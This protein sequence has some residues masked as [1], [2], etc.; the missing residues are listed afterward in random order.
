M[1]IET[2]AADDHP[3]CVSAKE[4]AWALG[5]MLQLMYCFQDPVAPSNERR[6][7]PLLETPCWGYFVVQMICNEGYFL[8]TCPTIR[9]LARLAW[10]EELNE[11]LPVA[12]F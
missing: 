4:M 7:C 11:R 5:C 10:P 1:V 3:F 6:S 2:A 9:D 8:D 12:R